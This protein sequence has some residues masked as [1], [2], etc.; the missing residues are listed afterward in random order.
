MEKKKIESSIREIKTEADLNENERKIVDECLLIR[1]RMGKTTKEGG[2]K[3]DPDFFEGYNFIVNFGNKLRQIYPDFVKCFLFH[4]FVGSTHMETENGYFDF[5]G[6]D[7]IYET[8]LKWDQD[9]NSVYEDL[10]KWQQEQ[11]EK[12]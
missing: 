10:K 1:N 5:P 2:N 6:E 12:E 3:Q 4:V 11:L 9:K 8:L 7:S